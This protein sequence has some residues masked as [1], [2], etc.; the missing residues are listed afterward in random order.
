MK[1]GRTTNNIKCQLLSSA[2]DIT[3]AGIG[4]LER[5]VIVAVNRRHLLSRDRVKFAYVNIDTVFKDLILLE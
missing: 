3:A 1:S 2:C 5:D 4:A